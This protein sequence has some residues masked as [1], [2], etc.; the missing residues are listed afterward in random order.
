MEDA[1]SQPYAG[2]YHTCMISTTG[3]TAHNIMLPPFSG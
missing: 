1:H 2:L 3:K